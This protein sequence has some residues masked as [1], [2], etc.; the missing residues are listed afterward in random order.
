M[1]NPAH[2]GL[3]GEHRKYWY[4]YCLLR[5]S[6]NAKYIGILSAVA[7]LFFDSFVFPL[8]S[9]LAVF[10]LV[11]AVLEFSVVKAQILQQ[12]G[13]VITLLKHRGKR[14][15]IENYENETQ[16]ALP[17]NG[18][19]A[20]FNGSYLKEHSHSWGIPTQRY[21]YDFVKIDDNGRTHAGD[22][23]DL[24][25]YYCYNEAIL[26]PADGRVVEVYNKAE[27]TILFGPGKLLSRSPHIAGNYVVIQ[28]TENEYSTLA[29][30]KKDSITVKPGDVVSRGQ[31]LAKCG[32]TGNS[33][34]PHLHFQL[35]DGQ[36]FFHSAGLPVKFKN[37]ALDTLTNDQAI[38]ARPTIPKEE[39]PEGYLTR[40]YIAYNTQG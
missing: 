13:V 18:K 24:Y 35:Q 7:T 2:T 9:V 28:H 26:A 34:E 1:A 20:V 10:V 37:V 39:I 22:P 19:W 33:T 25:A 23:T 11:E 14:P 16:Y 27:D 17:F 4:K 12:I 36:S 5:F 15:S 32:N 38:D 30:L 29:H 8:L 31:T 21:A 3:R 40:G 6:R